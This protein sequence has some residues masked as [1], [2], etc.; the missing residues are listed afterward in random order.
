MS[1]KMCPF[2]DAKASA[3]QSEAGTVEREIFLRAR[4]AG[5]SKRC[6]RD[7]DFSD[8]ASVALADQ[9]DGFVPALRVNLLHDSV[10]MI[11]DGEFGQIQIGGDFLVTQAHGDQ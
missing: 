3:Y 8:F 11:L 2:V 7:V 9:G 1:P 5:S 4:T 10:D 6:A